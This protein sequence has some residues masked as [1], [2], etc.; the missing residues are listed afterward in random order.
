MSIWLKLGS[1]GASPP[2]RRITILHHNDRPRVGNDVTPRE[3]QST[4]VIASCD[5]GWRLSVDS[6]VDI[7]GIP[8][9][10]PEYAWQ[11]GWFAA[12]WGNRHAVTLF[13]SHGHDEHADLEQGVMC[14]MGSSVGV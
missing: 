4:S 8:A 7:S 11:L 3:R 12:L 14:Q 6:G 1:A 10:P 13:G 2:I 9:D 5:G